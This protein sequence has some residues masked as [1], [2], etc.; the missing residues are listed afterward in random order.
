MK[1]S[2]IVKLMIFLVATL[3]LS[4]CIL[5]GRGGRGDDRFEHDHDRGDQHDHDREHHEG[6]H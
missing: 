6:D 5:D 1:H 3:L 2:R 4:G